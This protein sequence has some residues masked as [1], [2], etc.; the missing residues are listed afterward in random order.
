MNEITEILLRVAEQNYA[1]ARQHEDQRAAIAGLIVL[2]ATA[3]QGGLTQTGL[4]KNALP[5][6]IMLIVIGIFGMIAGIK[7]YERS[8]LHSARVRKLRERIDELNPDAQLQNSLDL[9]DQEHNTKYP[10]IARWVRL[11]I[12]WIVLPGII[13][14]LGFIYTF[15]IVLQNT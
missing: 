5:L 15:I 1:H 3:I 13:A 9:S 8:K 2:I 4:H 7:L 11:Y 12:L 6:T 14:S 10:F